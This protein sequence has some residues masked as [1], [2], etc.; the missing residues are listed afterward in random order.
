MRDYPGIHTVHL[1]NYLD[2]CRVSR[3]PDSQLLS[4]CDRDIYVHCMSVI[5]C[6]MV[7][8]SKQTGT[9]IIVVYGI[10]GFYWDKL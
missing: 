1:N 2:D 10:D 6:I 5:E 3:Y 8:H 9:L 4:N 7:E